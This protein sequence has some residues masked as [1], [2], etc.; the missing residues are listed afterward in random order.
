MRARTQILVLAVLAAAGAAWHTYA[1][2]L[3][4][5]RPLALV[6]LEPTARGAAAATG[7]AANAPTPV[8]VSPVR[9]GT[10]IERAESVGTVR[11]REAVTVTAKI[12]GMVTAIRF[13]EGQRVAAGAELIGLDDSALRAELDQARALLDD[14]RSQLQRAQRL[15]ASQAV[16]EQRVD[17]LQA[18]SRQAEGRVRQAQARLEEMRITAPFAGRVGLRQV[19]LGALIQPGTAVTTLDDLTRVRVEFAVPEVYLARVQ[20]GS[21][22]TARSSAFGERRFQ[23]TVLVVDTRIDPATRSVRLVSEFDNADEALRPGLFLTIELNLETRNDA[24]LIPE[25][26]IDPVGERAFVFVIRENRARR[27]EVQIGQRLTGEVEV[28]RGLRAEDKVVVRGLQRLRND[29]PVRVTETLTR[30]TS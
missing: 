4:V 2:Q 3:G 14:A 28:T 18:T 23:G 17:T 12:T 20:P 5:P 9:V 30:P 19:S 26:A 13:Q 29:A 7:G 1:D 8:A 15:V 22:V 21:R 16:A 6:G 24:L 10:V 11:A 25:E 27:I